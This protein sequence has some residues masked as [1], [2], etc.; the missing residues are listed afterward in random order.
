MQPAAD[1]SKK[2]WFLP[3]IMNPQRGCIL[4]LALVLG[5]RDTESA[6]CD[7]IRLTA[8]ESTLFEDSSIHL[9]P[10][11]SVSLFGASTDSAAGTDE[12]SVESSAESRSGLLGRLYLDAQYITLVTP[13]E[14]EA[15][16]DTMSGVR[17]SLNLPAPWTDRLPEFLQQDFFV[18]GRTLGLTGSTNLPGFAMSIDTHL[19]ELFIGTT[20]FTTVDETF[21]PF[22]QVGYN[23]QRVQVDASTGFGSFSEVDTEDRVFI[24]PGFELDIAEP[25]ALRFSAELDLD[26]LS[27]SIVTTELIFWFNRH[28]FARGGVINEADFDTYGGLIGGG[29][30]Y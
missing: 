4:V 3:I 13:D 9:F 28:L 6:F 20:L 1:R 17:G 21:H 10:T 5:I 15:L 16:S 19:D 14:L 11:Q 8:D 2:E 7:D 18:G 30:A 22:V 23:Y 12:Y 29:V 25:L 26:E 24:A 27:A